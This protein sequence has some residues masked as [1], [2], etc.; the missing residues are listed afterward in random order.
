MSAVDVKGPILLRQLDDLLSPVECADMLR[1]ADGIQDDVLSNV[2]WH[3]CRNAMY[4]QVVMVDQAL[5]AKLWRRV[6]PYVPTKYGGYHLLYLNS[7]FRF[8]R[9]PPGGYFPMHLD[10]CN[11]DKH[12]SGET[13]CAYFTLNIFLNDDFD[14]G[15]TDFFN[16]MKGEKKPRFSVQPKTGRAA[17]FWSAQPHRGNRVTRG[18]KYLLR[19]DVMGILH[20]TPAQLERIAAATPKYSE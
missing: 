16:K 11:E 19:T 5:A 14:G 13:T 17:L 10:G 4:D 15:H 2:A 9:Y 18:T 20:P 1:R 3:P 6:Q 7:Y 12:A 8:S